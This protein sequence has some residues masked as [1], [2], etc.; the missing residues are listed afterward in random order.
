MRILWTGMVL[1][2]SVSFAHASGF[3]VVQAG[4]AKC[5]IVVGKGALP[6]EQQAAD[7]LARCLR[8]MTGVA[9]PLV[10]EGTETA[11]VPRILVGPCAL[12]EGVMQAVKARD[13]GGYLIRQVGTDLVL[14]GPSEYGSANAVYGLLEDTLGCHWFMPSELFESIPTRA[15]VVLPALDVAVNPGFRFRFFSGVEGSGQ[16]QFRN[17]LDR[18]GNLNAP[19]LGSMGH[20]LYALYPPS[21]YGKEHPEYYPLIGGKRHVNT[22]DSDQSG[23]PCTSN[24]A[25]VQ[26]AVDYLNRYF[27]EHPQAHTHSVCINDNNT[28]CECEACRAQDVA[29][30]DFRGRKI[31]SD[32]YFTYVNAVARGVAAKHPDKFIGL[33]AY[34]G[35]EPTPVQIAKLEP[36]VYVGITQDC[37]QHFDAGYRRTDA[38]FIT[39]WQQKAAH[40]GKYEYYGLGAVVPRYY[41]HLIA[42]DIKHAKAVGLEGFHSEAYPLWAEFGPQIY[43]A[44]RMLY[45]PALNPDTLLKEFFTDLYGPAGPEMAAFYQTMEDAWMSYQRPGVWFEGIGSMAEQIRMY[46]ATDLAAM[47]AHLRRAGQ[48]ADRE[49]IKQRVAY[50]REGMGYALNLIEGWLAADKLNAL[51]ITP[52]NAAE[53]VRLVKQVNRCLDAAPRLWRSSIVN[54]PLAIQ[55]YK[56]GARANVLAQW[57]SRCQDATL[58]AVGALAATGS[59]QQSAELLATLQGTEIETLLRGQRGEFDTLPNLLPNG[60]FSSTDNLKDNQPTGPGWTSEDAPPGWGTWKIDE[61]KGKLYLDAS[62]VHGGKLAGAM[63]GGDCTCFIATVPVEAGK[64]YAATGWAFAEKVSATRQ[65]TLEVRWQDKDSKWFGGGLNTSTAVRKPGQWERLVGAVTAPEGAARAV[66]LLVVSDIHEKDR[67]W[68]DDISFVGVK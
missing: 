12:D 36:N 29:V 55:W 67:A 32:R 14:R 63:Q 9:V 61:G 10:A 37:A 64:R 65:T 7:D 39:Q 58:Q 28:W 26:V 22:D 41:P 43:L 47:R 48:L 30:P 42:Q 46:K 35:V 5:Q 52:A 6:V 19:F 24:P 54:D 50:V 31:Y 33:F 4:A 18:P 68:F 59:D 51:E 13:Y 34:Y 49:I 16:W 38:D 17:R 23:Q 27:D 21:K 15:E 11:G 60:S 1:L 53:A 40:V 62:R 3:A 25:V 2:A 8:T 57:S 20:I 56:D 44:A 66:I 45:N